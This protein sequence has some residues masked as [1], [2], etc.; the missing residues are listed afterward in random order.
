MRKYIFSSFVVLSFIFFIGGGSSLLWSWVAPEL[1]PRMVSEGYVSARIPIVISVTLSFVW[2]V[3]WM[4]GV[5]A[6]KTFFDKDKPSTD[7]GT[8]PSWEEKR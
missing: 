6:K 5:A 1:F 8:I 2:F 3:F 4:L 7:T